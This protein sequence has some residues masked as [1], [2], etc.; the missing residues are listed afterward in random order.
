MKT[1]FA[2]IVSVDLEKQYWSIWNSIFLLK[3]YCN[4]SL[5]E[6]S[7]MTAEERTWYISRYNE[8]MQKRKE[9]ERRNSKINSPHIPR[10]NV[11]R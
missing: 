5:Q 11:R 3:E 7:M 9:Q 6:Q 8:E 2:P 10:P 4:L 1:F